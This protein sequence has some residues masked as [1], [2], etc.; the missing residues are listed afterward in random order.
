[1]NHEEEHAMPTGNALV[2]HGAGFNI[3]VQ[4]QWSTASFNLQSRAFILGSLPA[5]ALAA[6]QRF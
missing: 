3:M 6:H 2:I 5:Q 1:M 4:H